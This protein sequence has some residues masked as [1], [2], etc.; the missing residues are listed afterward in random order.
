MQTTLDRF[1]AKTTPGPMPTEWTGKP[2]DKTECL[3]W[4]AG[5]IPEGY[6]QFWFNKKQIKAHRFIYEFFN[7]TIPKGLHLDHLCRIRNCVNLLHLEPVTPKENNNRSPITKESAR[8]TGKTFGRQNGLNCRKHNLPEGVC[9][10]RHKYRSFKK[11]NRKL[12]NLG[13]YNTPEE[14][15]LAYQEFCKK[16]KGES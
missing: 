1:L 11:I 10:N 12:I 3:L 2:E 14:A 8:N 7:G 5:K 13:T 6:G 16:I 15:S 4:T 9:K